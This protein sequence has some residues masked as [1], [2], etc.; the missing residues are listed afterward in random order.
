MPY[1]RKGKII[2]HKKNGRWVIK[3]KAKSIKNAKVII[4]ILTQIA[5]R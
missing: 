2:Y 1:K 5:R 4:R 3:Q